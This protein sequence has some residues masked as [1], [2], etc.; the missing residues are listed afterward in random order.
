MSHTIKTITCPKYTV[1]NSDNGESLENFAKRMKEKYNYLY[2]SE[3][4]LKNIKVTLNKKVNQYGEKEGLDHIMTKR[5]RLG[6]YEYDKSRIERAHWIECVFGPEC[7]NCEHLIMKR[8]ISHKTS[9][10]KN[11]RVNVCCKNMLY[12]VTL[13]FI[14]RKNELLI[15]TAF[16]IKMG[17][18]LKDFE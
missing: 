12:M 10:K 14:S 11:Y 16:P 3:L 4:K 2:D 13:E 8:D 18:Y 15:I 6:I 1:A 9:D 17:K 5:E 7:S